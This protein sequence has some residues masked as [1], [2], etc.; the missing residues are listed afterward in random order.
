MRRL[1]IGPSRDVA[2]MESICGFRP[3]RGYACHV[4]LGIRRRASGHAPVIHRS[5]WYDL[6]YFPRLAVG[7]TY[8]PELLCL[9]F[10]GEVLWASVRLELPF[11]HG[12]V[13]R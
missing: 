6:L 1:Y 3:G 9:C 13:M 4:R 2:R 11:C 7:R 5:I 12:R 8:T 10:Y